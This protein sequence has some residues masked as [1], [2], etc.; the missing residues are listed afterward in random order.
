MKKKH[1]RAVLWPRLAIENVE[2][3]NFDGVLTRWRRF[4][5]GRSRYKAQSHQHHPCDKACGQQ[6]AMEFVR[7]NKGICVSVLIVT[8]YLSF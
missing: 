2:V 7:E 5:M 6:Q 8:V 1:D 3:A 4:G